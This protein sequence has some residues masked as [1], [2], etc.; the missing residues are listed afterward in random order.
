MT[1]IFV[2]PRIRITNFQ[3]MPVPGAL[4]T[5]YD[6][7][8]TDLK[9][10]YKDPGMTTPH[11]NP[12]VADAGG[13]L[14]VIYLT[15]SYK[16]RATD[17]GGVL[18]YPEVDNLDTP[19]TSSG[20]VLGVA[21][22]GTG[23]STPE[24]ARFNLGAA[25][26]AAFDAL[27]STVGLIQ[28]AINGLPTFGALAA[29]SEVTP[30]DLSNDFAPVCIQRQVTLNAVRSSL[31]GII[32]QDNTAPLR[33]EGDTVFSVNFTPK[34]ATTTIRVEVVLHISGTTRLCVVA[35]FNTI[36][37]N[38]P[39]IA[40]VGH[41]AGHASITNPVVLNH[42]F[43]SPGTS[44]MTLQVNAGANAAYV[45]NG[46]STAGLFNGTM[47]SRLIIEEYETV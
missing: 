13:L 24:Q 39:A 11:T 44:Q 25:A 36:G 18:I 31:S 30:G 15:G 1:A 14:P 47:A 37:A 9:E 34:K 26:Q 40:S 2:P 22:G 45:L 46:S 8:T 3:G 43:A 5:F 21:Q 42:E 16:T 4:V 38:D 29:K 19:L 17:A 35:L 12:V 41:Y 6:A 32:P 7:G 28:S 10:I 23:G 20:G 27:S 33:N